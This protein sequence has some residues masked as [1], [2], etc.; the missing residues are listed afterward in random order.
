MK[1]ANLTAACVII[2][3]STGFASASFAFGTEEPPPEGCVSECE[4]PAPEKGNNG[5]GNGY[6]GE[7]PGTP[8]GATADTKKNEVIWDKFIGKFDGR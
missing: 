8:K 3:M 6:D 1:T 5:W 2:A 7:N 4:P